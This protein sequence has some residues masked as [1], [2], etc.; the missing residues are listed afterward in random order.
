MQGLL[1]R[2]LD[3]CCGF[4][5]DDSRVAKACRAL[6]KWLERYGEVHTVQSLLLRLMHH[7][8]CNG[9]RPCRIVVSSSVI[10]EL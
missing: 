7:R 10:V 5:I 8:C 6:L 2:L 4:I 9:L 3:H 1:L